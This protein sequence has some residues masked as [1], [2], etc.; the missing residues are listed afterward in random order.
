VTASLVT[1][2]AGFLGGHL[3]RTLKEE[4]DAVR[5]LDV[6]EPRGPVPGVEYRRGS[7]TDAAAVRSAVEGVDRI[8]HIA[9]TAE[10]WSPPGSG[11]LRVHTDGTRRIL[12]AGAAEG[13]DRIVHTSTEAILRDFGGSRGAEEGAEAGAEGAAQ[14]PGANAPAVLGDGPLLPRPSE[15]PE[16]YCRHKL[17]A[18]RAALEAAG[19]GAPVVIVSPGVPMGPDDRNLTPPSRMLQGFLNG[20]FP[21]FLDGWIS[22]V[23]VR[24]VA[25]AYLRVVEKGE[26]GQRYVVKGSERRLGDLLRRIEVLTGLRMPR[27]RIPS[28]LALGT[29]TLSELVAR[30]RSG[31]SPDAT[32]A[33]VKIALA[34]PRDLGS[35][36]AEEL[37]L[38]PRSLDAT[39]T[40]AIR[41][42][43]D[44]GLL[45]RQLPRRL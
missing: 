42:L 7:V 13:V 31:A 44:E 15:V 36:S 23:D 22:V 32:V 14:S 16:G 5:V 45:E 2:G 35:R 39:L 3:V 18:E 10:L 9:G 25:E 37:G 21:A 20:R 4:G 17:E 38:S 27:I 12:E 26:P 30:Y 19:R 24:D 6:A 29:A 43:R 41:W 8:F 33:G 11:A 28:A 1:G 34:P 40:A